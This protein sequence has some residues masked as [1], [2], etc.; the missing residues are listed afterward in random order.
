MQTYCPSCHSTNIKKN[1]KTYYGKQNHR[2]KDCGRQ[3][4]Y[5][6][7]HIKSASVKEQVSRALKE[8]L[9][10]YAI[11]RIFGLSYS[12]LTAFARALWE[13]TPRNLGIDDAVSS[14]IKRVQVFGIQS[15][16]MWSFVNKKKEKRWIWIAYDPVHRLVVACHIGCRGIRSARAFWKKIPDT[17]KNCSFETDDWGAY[18]KIIP[19]EKHKI[20]KDLTYYI[21][22]FNATVRARVSRLVRKTLSFSKKDKWHNKAILWFLWQL[23]LER[24]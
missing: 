4:V 24:I 19:C 10:L 23:N 1:G 15:D 2:C 5:G 16:E 11:C 14:R 7:K 8:R 22:G 13:S 17:L 12:W 6:S 18:K 9:S 21:E 20:G 3:F